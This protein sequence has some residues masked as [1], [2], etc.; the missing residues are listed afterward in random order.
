MRYYVETFEQFLRGAE[1]SARR[2][3]MLMRRGI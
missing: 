2:L 3:A 1:E